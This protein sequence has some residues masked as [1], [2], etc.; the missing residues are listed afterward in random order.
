MLTAEGFSTFWTTAMATRDISSVAGCSRHSISLTSTRFGFIG[1]AVSPTQAVDDAVAAEKAGFDSAWIPDHFT[2]VDGDKLEPWTLLSAISARTKKIL[3]GS[4]VTDT[5]R[6]HPSRTAHSTACLD[7]L[8]NGRV[9][10][11][12][13]AG[14]AMNIVPFGLPWDEPAERFLRLQEAVRVIKLLWSS[15][16]QERVNFDGKYYSLKDAFLS[17]QPSRKPHPPVYIGAMSSRRMLEFIGREGDGWFA[18]LNSIELFKKRWKIISDAAR[19][20][21]RNPRQIDAAS[22]LMVALPRNAEERNAAMLGGKTTLLMEKSTLESLGYTEHLKFLQ[23][24]NFTISNDYVKKIFAAASEIPDE[25]V[26]RTMAIGTADD[27]REQIERFTKAGVKHLVIADHLA[28]KTTKRTIEVFRK[29]MK[30]YR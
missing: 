30:E 21:G 13:G 20:A 16:R 1:V 6:T 12:I 27:I 19:A 22:H 28:P 18:W 25:Y 2:D 29:L 14:E 8:S 26:H 3:L 7:S 5:Q 23:Y 17:Q 24:Q 11:G 4:S 15:T 10:L 9:I